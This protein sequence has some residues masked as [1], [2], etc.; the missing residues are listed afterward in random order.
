MARSAPGNY[1]V[2]RLSFGLGNG[3]SIDVEAKF[4]LSDVQRPVFAAG[5]ENCRFIATAF[6]RAHPPPASG[7]IFAPRVRLRGGGGAQ[8]CIGLLSPG[9]QTRASVG[10]Y[11][12]EPVWSDQSVR[13]L[14]DSVGGKEPPWPSDRPA[15]SL[16]CSR[17]R[18]RE[19]KRRPCTCPQM[20]EVSVLLQSTQHQPNRHCDRAPEASPQHCCRCIF[21][22]A[23]R[24]NTLA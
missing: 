10:R 2:N 15:S 13:T 5:K 22:S 11:H 4:R 18:L 8:Y 6:P 12:T 21:A 14:F 23:D 16:V 1:G 9:I 3:R 24:Q 20:K 19:T 7:A 17:A